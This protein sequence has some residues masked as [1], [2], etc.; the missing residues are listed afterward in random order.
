MAWGTQDSMKT[1]EEGGLSHW[2]AVPHV[3]TC[4]L[5]KILSLYFP[6]ETKATRPQETKQRQR[7]PDRPASYTGEEAEVTNKLPFTS[8]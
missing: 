4:S 8:A 2:H 6:E 5:N 7:A 1:G 3:R